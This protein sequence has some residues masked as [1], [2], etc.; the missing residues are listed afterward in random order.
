[1]SCRIWLQRSLTNRRKMI[2]FLNPFS[3]QA[4]TWTL[5]LALLTKTPAIAFTSPPPTFPADA[6]STFII[7]FIYPRMGYLMRDVSLLGEIQSARSIPA[8]DE[9]VS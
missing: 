4:R 3:K 8:L 1:M 2:L 5:S 7:K 9:L 6:F